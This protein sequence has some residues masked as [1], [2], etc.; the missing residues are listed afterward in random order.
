ML[1]KLRLIVKITIRLKENEDTCTTFYYYAEKCDSEQTFLNN[2]YLVL[3]IFD[4]ILPF[5]KKIFFDPLCQ[6]LT[7]R[8]KKTTYLIFL[9]KC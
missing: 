1:I 6:L 4:E 5:P 8:S 2:V 7:L 3:G 9:C